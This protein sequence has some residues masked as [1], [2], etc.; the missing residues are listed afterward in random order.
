M[1]YITACEILDISPTS[2]NSLSL[3]D[4]KLTKV[5]KSYYRMALKYHPDKGGDPRLFKQIK[6]AYDYII[7][8]ELNGSS[9]NENDN[10]SDNYNNNSYQS[11]GEPETFET[12]F[13]SFV[14]CMVK[15]RKGYERFDKLF[16]KTTLQSIL[17]K[18]DIYS[19]KMFSQLDVDKCRSI[20]NFL[21]Q[22]KEVFY[23][24]NEQLEK[25]KKVIQDKIKNNNIILLN[26]SLNDILNDNIY[27]LDLEEDTHYIP[28]WHDEIIVDD[29]I[30]K[31][32]PDLSDNI[33][34][35]S[36]HDIAI[37]CKVSLLELFENGK[38]DIEIG[39]KVVTVNSE[40]VNITKD[41]QLIVYKEQGKIIPNKNNL[42][43]N[44]KRGNII[45]EL[46][47]YV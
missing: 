25:Y 22:N 16:I 41:P 36:N 37:K 23:F 47:L 38:I 20:Y 34:I 18:C 29:M 14:E 33:T 17:K 39:D 8:N 27:K 44:K 4:D 15:N 21:S 26:P 32:I 45:V 40:Q 6:E 19:I 12:I 1:N 13:V 2:I 5:K 9:V 7:E 42:Y 35:H 3:K 28:L 24:T 30:I 43:N 31:N 11:S 46:V 10:Y